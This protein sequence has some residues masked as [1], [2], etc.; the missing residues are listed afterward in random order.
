MTIRKY[1]SGD[2]ARQKLFKGLSL[3]ADAVGATSGP[4]GRTIAIQQ[5]WGATKLTKD[6]VSVARS[7]Q[8]PKE[9]GEGAKLLI[10]AAEKTNTDAGD[11]TTATCILSKA[12]VEEG[13]KYIN[14]G[15]KSTFIKKGID[16]AVKDVVEYL[17]SKSKQITDNEQI[18]QIAT[19]SANGDEEIGGLIAQAI[20]KVG[21][22]GVVTVEEAKGL[23]TEL[24]VVEGMEIDQG[25]LSPY[26]MTNL[27]KSLVEFDNPLLFLYD[28]KINSLKQILP[29]LEAVSQ[30][31]RPLVFIVDDCDDAPLG[32]LI[33][34]HLK[35]TLRCCVV[36][37]PSFGDIRKS[38]MEDIAILT[39]GQFISS[40]LGKNLENLNTDCLGSC[41]SIKISPNSTIIVNGDGEKE[42][43]AERVKVIEGEIENSESS[44]DKE[45]LRER[46]ARLTS[47]IAV[48]RVGGATEVEVNEKKDRVDD[49]ACATR[50]ALEEGILPG[51]GVALVKAK[52]YLNDPANR[53][54]AIDKDFDIGYDI[55]MNALTASLK[56]IAENAGYAPDVIVEKV[57]ESKDF[58]YGLNALTGTY[59]NFYQT[60]V[61]DATKAIRCALENGASVAGSIL[62]VEGLVIDDIDEI[63]KMN[64]LM[65][66]PQ[67]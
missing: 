64:Q 59:E 60:G 28:G 44:Y 2:E 66:Q 10:Q 54:V 21:K 1:I 6:G 41:G 16:Q 32:A 23:K 26:F 17:K 50:A 57:L 30:T 18:R 27:E 52:Q 7:F 31:G 36:K 24:E 34:N 53:K 55:V 9:E 12:I 22:T 61:V 65:K 56:K 45:K 51:G 62:T 37:A 8:L 19:I 48:I 20:E 35:G 42:E 11:A 3:V 25:Y 47:G 14:K 5:Q 13:L 58:D 39:G 63:I 43:I 33:Q 46:L 49:A 29:M 4:A 15:C 67:M 38:I 40:I